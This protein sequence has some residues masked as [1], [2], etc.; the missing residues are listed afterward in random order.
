MVAP[1]YVPAAGHIIKVNLDPRAGHEQGGWR[2][3]MVLSPKSYNGKTGLAV[4]VPITKQAKGYPFEVQ[5]PENMK[6][7]GV[8]LSDAVKNIDWQ[9]RKAKYADTAPPEVMEAVQERLLALLG[10]SE[11]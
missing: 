6:V 5:L 9:A 2:P 1:A 11:P 8:V 4:V 10:I 3:A 7:T